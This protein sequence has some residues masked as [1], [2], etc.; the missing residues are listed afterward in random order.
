MP[1]QR[2]P[3][4]KLPDEKSPT[5][6][7]TA[8]RNPA[9]RMQELLR[10]PITAPAADEETSSLLASSAIVQPSS[11]EVQMPAAEETPPAKKDD[12]TNDN[13]E[14]NDSYL[15]TQISN[16]VSTD[17]LNEPVKGLSTQA[18]GEVRKRVRAP[19]S[20]PVPKREIEQAAVLDAH[21]GIRIRLQSQSGKEANVR[22]SVDV[23]ETLHMRIKQ[24]C[25][26]HRIPSSRMLII[27]LLED[28]LE[29]EGF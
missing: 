28:Y 29:G 8:S 26:M 3:D 12:N 5:R 1:D 23:S 10:K 2:L 21:A 16:Q 22:L 13:R 25:A 19:A 27:A 20:K 7:L 24:Y 4:E 18:N 6:G 14:N 11:M 17:A 15:N 9:Q